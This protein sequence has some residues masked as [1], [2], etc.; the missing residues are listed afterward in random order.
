MTSAV[1]IAPKFTEQPK[2]RKIGKAVEFEC[3]LEAKP[4]GDVRWSKAGALI[5][6]GGRYT[7]KA[8]T[9]GNKH[10]LTLQIAD[11]NANDGGEYV[12]FSKNA[13]G[14]ASANIKL[15]LGQSKPQLKAPKFPEKP[16]IRKDAA[17][18]EIV[19]ACSLEG[20]PRPELTYFLNDRQ[21]S[22]QPGKLTFIYKEA[23][24][25]V[26]DCEIRI[27]NPTPNDGGGYK[28][29]A[30]NSA[31]E[32]NASINLNLS[33]KAS[34]DEAPKFQPSSVRKDGKAVV[35]EA[36]CTGVPAPKFNWTK[37]GVELKPRV[38]KY[39]LSSRIDGP[40]FV[41][42]LRILNFIDVDADVY[43]CNAKNMAGESKATHTIKVPKIIGAPKVTYV[44]KQ[45]VVELQAEAAEQEPTIV[46]RK[47]GKTVTLDNRFKQS[48]RT[49]GGRVII[50]L[51]V[52]PVTEA[53]NG[54]YECELTNSYGSTKS[55][56]VIKAA[57]DEGELPKLVSKPSDVSEEEGSTLS[58]RMNYS[59][60]TAPTV[61]ISRRGV[62]VTLDSRALV[63]VD[64][65]NKSISLTIRSLKPEDVG[66]Y[67][68]QL[69]SRGQQCDSATFNVTVQ[70]QHRADMHHLQHASRIHPHP[71]LLSPRVALLTR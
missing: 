20:N 27:A 71:H 37:G 50:T 19:L 62:D 63:K 45:A 60:S 55:Q 29:K 69:S 17:T 26:Y 4:I 61:K 34:K 6:P 1:G 13:S 38:G 30:V 33:A 66:T 35:I 7:I 65:P 40:V 48:I 18:G 43:V 9:N 54:T 59:G 15:N 41:Q 2:I 56:F 3:I 49:E 64:H 67:T 25:D 22:S 10:V 58:M 11:I 52:D 53:D 5:N 31:G 21:I 32:S 51:S 23:G 70:E 14:E 16:V 57:K 24:S 36:R 28:I 47:N 44:M 42:I 39:E 46:W 12:V 68:V 8:V